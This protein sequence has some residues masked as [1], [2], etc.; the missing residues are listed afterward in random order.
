MS[1]TTS[2]ITQIMCAFCKGSGKDPFN[3]LSELAACQVCDGTGKVEVE[4][5][6]IKCAFCKGT[7]VYH[8]SRITCTVCG[9]KGMVTAPKGL[10]EQCP[11]CKGTGIAADSRLPC[12]GC[13]GKGVISK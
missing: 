9:G 8:D 13:K 6:A 10:T 2:A 3:L 11:E 5:P 1:Q 7:G 12:L 4:E